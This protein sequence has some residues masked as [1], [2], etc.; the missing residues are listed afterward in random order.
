MQGWNIGGIGRVCAGTGIWVWQMEA[1]EIFSFKIYFKL[2]L[3]KISTRSGGMKMRILSQ[4]KYQRR[5]RR[6]RSTS[7]FMERKLSLSGEAC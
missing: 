3:V 2:A 7:L 6:K 1:C 4:I 5:K